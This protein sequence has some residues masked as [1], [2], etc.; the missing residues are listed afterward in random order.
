MDP[1][2]AGGWNSTE[3]LAQ[4]LPWPP[5]TWVGRWE[6][7]G[8]RKLCP[9]H[10]KGASAPGN[11]DFRGPSCCAGWASRREAGSKA[12]GPEQGHVWATSRLGG[13][14][15][16]QSWH[17]TFSSQSREGKEA[18]GWGR[19]SWYWERWGGVPVIFSGLCFLCLPETS[20]PGGGSWCAGAQ[21][22]TCP[23][24]CSQGSGIL[25]RL[26]L[27]ECAPDRAP[28]TCSAIRSCVR[29]SLRSPAL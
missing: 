26:Q 24:P 4:P 1:Q 23:L 3:A 15:C 29:G 8:H 20:A 10:L 9:T 2:E 27:G 5:L 7:G 14:L 28:E 6:E 18:A 12:A 21:G 17:R 13:F 11:E 16:V 25:W 22:P 19:V